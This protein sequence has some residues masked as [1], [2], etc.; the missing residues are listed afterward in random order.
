LPEQTDL[1]QA[2]LYPKFIELRKE[3]QP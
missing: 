1:L 3:L 2:L